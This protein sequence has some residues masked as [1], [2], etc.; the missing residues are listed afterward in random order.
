MQ[1]RRQV[2]AGSMVGAAALA[3]PPKATASQLHAFAFQTGS[4][5]VAP[6]QI[7]PASRGF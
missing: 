2:M 6:S 4:W 5:R 3:I 7:G 1:T